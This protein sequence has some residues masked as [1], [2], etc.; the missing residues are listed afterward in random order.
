MAD[1]RISELAALAGAN[2]AAGDLLPVVDVSA[3]ETKK[4]TVTDLVGNAT[5]L[6]ADATIPGAKILFGSSQVPGSALV[7]GGVSTAKLANDAVT[8]AKLGDESTVDLVTALPATGAFIGQ[9]AI[10][11]G[12]LKTYCWNGSTWQSI[13]AAGSVN[14]VIGSGSGIVNVSVTTSGDQVTIATTLDSTSAAGQFLGGPSSGAGAV[15]YR[16]IIGTDLPTPTTSAKGGVIVNGE[17]LRMDADTLEIDNDITASSATYRVVQYSNKGLITAGRDI[18]SADLPA[19]TAGAIGAV[20]PGSGL[21][22][23]TAGALNHSSSVTAG[24]ATKVTFNAQG[25]ITGSSNLLDTDIPSL[26]AN[27]LTSGTI[28]PALIGTN[29]I[30]G[31]K[32]A[33][34]ST[35]KFG[36]AGSTEG[37]VTFP[38]AEFQGQYFFDALNGDLYLYDGAAWQPITIT[39][40]ELV[41][42]GTYNAA[43]NLVKSVTAAGTAAGL[44]VGNALPVASTSNLRYYVVVSDSGTGTAPAPTVA[45]AP[46]DMI[47]SGGTTWELIDVSNAIAGQIA[48]NISFT[49]YSDIAATNVQTALQ[50]LQDE[51]LA[52][53]GGMITGNLEIGT[54][55]SLTWEGS[56]ADGF[57]TT[58]A[59]VDPTADRT[60]TLPNAT[61][62]VVLS[63]AIVNADIDAAAA[64]VDTKLA[65]I[66]TAG[67]VSNSATTATSANTAS[68]IVARDGTGNF[69]AGT[70]TATTFSGSGASLTSLT[71]G[72]LSGTIPTGVLGNSNLFLGTTSVALNRAS[73]NQA[74][75]G[76]SSV[77]LPGATSGSVTLQPA[78]IA[79]TTTITLPATTGTL[80]TTGDTG[81][82]TNTMLAGSIADTKLAT[83]S[84]ASKVSNSATTATN[85]NTASAI[86]AR[87][88]SGNFAAGQI[89][90]TGA[91]VGTSTALTN[92]YAIGT[93]L[94]PAVQIEG[95]TGN[96]AALSITRHASA[97]ANLLLQRGVTGTPVADTEPVG[98]IN[99]NGFDGTNYF[100][101]A[102]IRAVVDGTPGANSMPGR[103]SLQTTP[104]G[105]TTPVER[106]RLGPAGQ[107]LAASL[108]TELLPVWSFTGDPN[109]GLYSPGAD[110][111]ALSTSGTQRLTV[112]AVGNVTIAGQGDL[113]FADADSS[114]WVAFQ[115][116]ATVASN[117][118]WTLPAADG[119][120]GQLLKT[121]GAG[122]LS[123]Q[124]A[125]TAYTITTTA[126][127]K[128]L[129]NRER[130]T[131][132]ASGQTIT[133]PATPAAGAEVTITIAGTFTDTIVARNGVNIMSLAENMTIDKA[134]V[135]VT[136]YY[137]DATRG[138][139]II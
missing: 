101:A 66:S 116:P 96:A 10:D 33:N 81:T 67:K 34:A 75:T 56:T 16:N 26:P 126:V 30:V 88:G 128:T 44:V 117:V 90:S 124:A 46:P 22:M 61:G 135:S 23:G 6:I 89:A 94:A 130:C 123:W 139:R 14:T 121:D 136:L 102:L 48:S 50:E 85:T 24:T 129:A 69:T 83:I 113:R 18:T 137:V 132:T 119:V 64:I 32:L 133:L 127:S 100:N 55:G 114:N 68:T 97:A 20:K 43:T 80:V 78:A 134:D 115:A 95:N 122:V 11:T 49:P 45:L 8:A 21:T 103:L 1:L 99:F 29:A 36:G 4:I 37:V 53:T 77:A 38:A 71:A 2:L 74:L 86:V 60:I 62:T 84:T 106:L 112:D 39:A 42:A 131:V 72:N 105:S 63:G 104:S 31:A 9:L 118:T 79:G 109:T 52:K 73:A 47:V 54:A 12:N 70:I 107:I 111:L 87:D 41:Y 7:D 40:G 125:A 51:K 108:G 92:A 91:L 59:V 27:K 93:A 58:L 19:A 15:S 57:E 98:Q 25:H 76:I 17:G 3:S 35:V 28:D 138:W 110:Q 120:D 13:K 65:T 82:V 5:T